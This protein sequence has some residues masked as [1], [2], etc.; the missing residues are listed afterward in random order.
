MRKEALLKHYAQ[1]ARDQAHEAPLVLP[2]EALS[3]MTGNAKTAV[4][5]RERDLRWR[6]A[7]RWVARAGHLPME[8]QRRG[9]H[10]DGRKL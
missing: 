1:A 5:E 2:A 3:A 8:C 9:G 7:G 10:R 4:G 6:G